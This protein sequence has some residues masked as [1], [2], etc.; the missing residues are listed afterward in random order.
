MNLT[1]IGTSHI[2]KQSL[3]EV[4]RIITEKKPE[5]IALELDVKRYHAIQQKNRKI[6]IYSIRKVGIKG[7]LFA[8]LG[9]WVEKE[10]GKVVDMKPGS[11][12]LKAIKIAK[13]Q[14][15]RIALIDQD[16]D[17]TLR[18][19]SLSWK[20]RLNFLI[21]IFRGI[22]FRKKEIEEL[23]LN[24]FD[25]TKVPKKELI[26][27]LLSKVKR[28]YPS[29]YKVLIKERNEIMAHNLKYIMKQYPGKGI[30][31]VIGAG[32][33]EGVAQLLRKPDMTSTINSLLVVEKQNT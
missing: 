32:H 11:E 7:F 25:L 29:L 27:K 3:E 2:A 21:D 13:K 17:I 28:R 8:L 10:L 15:I 16:I 18:K 12:M 6:D 4:E 19:I 31:S 33:E 24:D 30:V 20:E 5:I 9:A 26:G 22:F 23:G 1:I 14:K